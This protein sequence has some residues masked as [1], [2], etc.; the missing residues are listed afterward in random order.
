MNMVLIKSRTVFH[1]MHQLH[2]ISEARNCFLIAKHEGTRKWM[3]M[4]TEFILI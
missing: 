2:S 4:K 1:G 3:E